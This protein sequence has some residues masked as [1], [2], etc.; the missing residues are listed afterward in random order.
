VLGQILACVPLPADRARFRAACWSWRSTE[1]WR[2]PWIVHRDGTFIC[3]PYI[4]LHRLPL[5][6]SKASFVLGATNGWLALE[7]AVE[8]NGHAGSYCLH[9]PFT[10]AT[11]PLLG[12]GSVIVKVSEWFDVRKVLMR[13]TVDD[14]IV[15]TTNNWY[16]PVILCRAGKP[17]AWIPG[18]LETPYARIID[19]EFLGDRLY[20]ITAEEELVAFDLDED[21]E[22]VP[23]VLSFTYMIR[24]PTSGEE[25]EDMD[26]YYV[27][28]NSEGDD[29]VPDNEVAVDP[30]L[31][32]EDHIT[33]CWHLLASNGKLLMVRRRKC[34]PA[35]CSR[36]YS[37][38]I[39][40]L[41]ADMIIGAWVPADCKGLEEGQ[42]IFISKRFCKSV[43]APT[44][45]LTCYFA[46]Q[47]DIY[48]H[49]SQPLDE[50]YG[51]RPTWVFPPEVG[52]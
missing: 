15:V 37:I 32:P 46:D 12:L 24:N 44:K 30:H 47:C 20:G 3:F 8:G 13:S 10:G 17:G 31:G 34:T 52:P 22:G 21:D 2:L 29:E 41:K 11:L 49:S 38:K 18:P 26:D 5:P 9:N 45:K 6:D 40:V 50:H 1:G 51:T 25:E 19:V 4:G 39:E 33:D 27:P 35:A 48:D 14:V 36:E 16:Y 28:E 7:R 23:T 43:P 42:N